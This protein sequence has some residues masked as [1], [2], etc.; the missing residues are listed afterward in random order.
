MVAGVAHEINTPLAYCSSNIEV[1]KEQLVGLVALT[2]AGTRL[3]ELLDQPCPSA[4]ALNVKLAQIVELASGLK[5]ENTLAVIDDLLTDS[6]VALQEI[7]EMVMNL[8]NLQPRRSQEN[9]Q[10]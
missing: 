10:R 5:E 3:A 9:R 7:S 4:D 1:V 8:K 6:N 2:G